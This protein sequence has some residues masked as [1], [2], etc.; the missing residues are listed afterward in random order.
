MCAL[1]EAWEM[2]RWR[3]SAGC[4]SPE[5]AG[6]AA[7]TSKRRRHGRRHHWAVFK[8]VVPDQ[9]HVLGP[10]LPKSNTL[11]GAQTWTCTVSR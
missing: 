7:P 8:C 11:D 4:R 2:S 1:T 9:D 6:S 3:D 5:P 10:G